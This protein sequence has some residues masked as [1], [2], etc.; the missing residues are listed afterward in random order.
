MA[1]PGHEL[2][3]EGS[4][5]SDPNV[6]AGL[7]RMANTSM[8]LGHLDLGQ[9]LSR[10]AI[11]DRFGTLAAVGDTDVPSGAS[12]RGTPQGIIPAPTRPNRLLDFVPTLPMDGGSIPYL[13]ELATASP[14]GSG[15]PAETVEG[16]VKPSMA[17]Q[18]VDAEAFARTIAAW[19][20]VKRQTLA[21]VAALQGAISYRL[22]NNVLRR[23]EYQIVNGDGSGENLRGV[24]NTTGV[25]VPDVSGF[26][27]GMDKV[28]EGIVA[29]LLAEAVPNLTLLNPV[30]WA[31]M[32]RAKASGD[33]QYFS[34]GAFAVTAEAMWGTATLPSPAIAP[35]TALVGDWS[36]GATV[37]VREGV[38]VRASDSDQNDFVSNKVTLLGEGRFAF[39]VWQ[40]G[41]F[42]KVDLS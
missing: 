36:Q 4:F 41:C 19:T 22:N 11:V 25:A 18:F 31:N 6:L 16:A 35:D 14:S 20:K 7:E 10:D 30:D 37:L 39:P 1:Q 15:M 38:T 42:A 26:T 17:L 28:L 24:L 23:L 27:V 8:P 40:P 9:S 2:H 13:Q 29:V 21:D 12:R 32:I 3:D 33:G 34:S 5:L